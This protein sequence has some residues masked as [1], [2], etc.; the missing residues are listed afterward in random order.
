M[1]LI[2]IS[3]IPHLVKLETILQTK[4][5]PKSQSKFWPPGIVI[6]CVCPSVRQSIRH[7]VRPH[8]NSSP[9][10]ARITNFAPYE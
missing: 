4:N 5:Q 7:Q 9:V 1:E 2:N 10:Q 8:D 3:T 6:A